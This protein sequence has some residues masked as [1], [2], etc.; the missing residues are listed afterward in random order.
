MLTK[1]IFFTRTLLLRFFFA[2]VKTF[3][4]LQKLSTF[5]FKVWLMVCRKALGMSASQFILKAFRWGEVIDLCRP[6]KFFHYH[7]GKPNSPC[8]MHRSIVMLEYALDWR[9]DITAAYKDV[10]T[11]A[12]ICFWCS[13]FSTLFTQ[14]FGPCYCNL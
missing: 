4:F 2:V 3:T 12:G 9:N 13:Y 14:Y 6:L 1:Y 11:V 5:D 10:P 8:F 7:L